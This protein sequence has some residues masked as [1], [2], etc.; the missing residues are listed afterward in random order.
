[1]RVLEETSKEEKSYYL[2]K[3]SEWMYGKTTCYH[4]NA[5][6]YWWNYFFLLDKII[7]LTSWK[8]MT[9]LSFSFKSFY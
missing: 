8:F 2:I 4:M 9:T 3:G 1:M 6:N 5:S 7:F